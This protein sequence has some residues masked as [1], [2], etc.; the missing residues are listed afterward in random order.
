MTKTHP[1][2][3]REKGLIGVKSKGN[4]NYIT[5]RRPNWKGKDCVN[6]DVIGWGRVP[7]V[8]S[9]HRSNEV[10]R[11]GRRVVHLGLSPFEKNV[12]LQIT[13][14]CHSLIW[15]VYLYFLS[16]DIKCTMYEDPISCHIIFVFTVKISS[17]NFY[18]IKDCNI[19]FWQ[20]SEDF[21]LDRHPNTVLRLSCRRLFPNFQKEGL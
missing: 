12:C 20:A 15:E 6:W 13:F 4:T 5:W 2:R 18:N 17:Y 9:L 16:V 8:E 7:F 19:L 11:N 21:P 14:V 3:G 1:E 10:G